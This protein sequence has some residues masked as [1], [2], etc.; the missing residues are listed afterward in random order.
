MDSPTSCIGECRDSES[1]KQAGTETSGSPVEARG[2]ERGRRGKRVLQMLPEGGPVSSSST[3][4]LVEALVSKN[5]RLAAYKET[6]RELRDRVKTLEE[7]S[8]DRIN[9]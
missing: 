1:G 4:A 6:I 7:E 5:R 3:L 2:E 8:R 9:S